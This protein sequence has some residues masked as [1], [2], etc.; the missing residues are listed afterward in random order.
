MV[1]E[2]KKAV[3]GTGDGQDFVKRSVFSSEFLLILVYIGLLSVNVVLSLGISEVN[4][5]YIRELVLAWVF[6]RQIGKAVSY[7]NKNK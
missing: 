2:I 4:L 6:G 1:E 3:F 5:G 7:D